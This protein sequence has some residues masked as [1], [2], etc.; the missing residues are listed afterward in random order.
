MKENKFNKEMFKN[1]FTVAIF[2]SARLKKTDPNYKMV[3]QMG[4]R[5]AKEGLE[6]VT[7]R[8]PGVMEAA[9]KGHKMGQGKK[10]AH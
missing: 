10:K 9:N 2:G 7:G 1:H 4:K 6:I 8:G 5:I 3:E